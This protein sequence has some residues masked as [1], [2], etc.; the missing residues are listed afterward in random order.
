MQQVGF[1]IYGQTIANNQGGTDGGGADSLNPMYTEAAIWSRI[2]RQLS[3]QR[4]CFAE[5]LSEPDL[6]KDELP[7]GGYSRL[8]RMLNPR[9]FFIFL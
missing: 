3:K 8:P 1:A 6:W 7:S 4:A 9:F 2:P 5:A